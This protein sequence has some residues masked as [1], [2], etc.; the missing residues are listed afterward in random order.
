MLFLL[1]E[2]AGFRGRMVG[3]DYSARSVQLAR[4]IAGRKELGERIVFERWDVMKEDPAEWVRPGKE[5][6]EEGRGEGGFEVVLDKGTFDAISLN[7]EVDGHGRRMCESYRG[8]VEGLVKGGGY[9]LVTSCNW[10]EGE[11]RRWFEG[12]ELEFYGRIKY[13]SFAFG[14]KTGQSISSVC[15]RR[16]GS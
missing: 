5:E 1:R 6:E 14:G 10:T 4:G 3:V 8:R 2:E 9:L 16:R 7:E 11:L 12:G 13:P 15:F